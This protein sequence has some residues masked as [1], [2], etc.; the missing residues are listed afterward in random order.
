MD[1]SF[2]ALTLGSPSRIEAESTKLF[3]ETAPACSRITYAFP[4]KGNRPE[5]KVVWRDGSLYPPR[6]KEITD[7]TAWP[8]DTSGQMWIGDSGKM[9]AGIYDENPRLLDDARQADITSHPPAQKYPRTESVDAE[10]IA[11][12]K[13]GTPAGSQFA[14]H[15]GPLTDI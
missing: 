1:A 10:C 12:C 14:H 3:S 11:A 6:P 2:W 7:P 9:V 15:S 5:V 8:F 4:A 13:G